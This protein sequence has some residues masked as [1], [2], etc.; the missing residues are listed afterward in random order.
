M[1]HFGPC[2]AQVYCVH[3]DIKSLN[4]EIWHIS[5]KENT[6]A[7]TLWRARCKGEDDMV[8][9]DQEVGVDFFELAQ[10]TVNEWSTPA[11]HRSMKMT[12]KWSAY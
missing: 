7:D 4:P 2:D 11:L 6:M 8:L 12:T 3:Q 9:E 10:L 1:R 5:G